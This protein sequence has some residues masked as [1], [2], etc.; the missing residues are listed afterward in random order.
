MRRL[1][2]LVALVLLLGAVF[3]VLRQPSRSGLEATGV[4][5]TTPPTVRS[6]DSTVAEAPTTTEP[7]TDTTFAST[8]ALPTDTTEFDQG[9]AA[10]AFAVTEI[11]FGTNGFVSIKNVGDASGNLAGFA[12]CSRPRYFQIP[13]VEL[14]PLEIAWIA[15]GDGATLGDGAGIAQTVIAMN[16]QLGIPSR[17]GGELALYR[18][19]DFEN[20][21]LMV[22]YVEWG[23]A[24]HG[25]SEVA[26]AA[27]LWE[28]E[29]FIV[30]PA[31]AFGIQSIAP[32]RAAA[33]PD[34]WTAG[35]GG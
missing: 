27:S 8:T 19:S 1:I 24:G 15:F 4:S 22:T 35:V 31:D 10:A 17:D 3:F 28:P 2:G 5:S 14:Q 21:E 26:I 20:P 25:R 33:G 16:G 9:A 6:T 13:D 11:Q 23:S 12:L 29:A 7:A 34:D 18:S 30:V 32:G